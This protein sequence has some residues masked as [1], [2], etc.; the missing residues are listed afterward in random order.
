M[1]GIAKSISKSASLSSKINF[2]DSTDF[3]LHEL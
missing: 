3:I 2:L 1:W